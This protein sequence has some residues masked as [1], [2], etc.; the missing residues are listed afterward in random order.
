MKA[1]NRLAIALL[2][3]FTWQVAAAAAADSITLSAAAVKEAGIVIQSVAATRF[4]PKV[5]ARGSLLDPSPVLSL[6]SS[7]SAATAKLVAAR[8][9][10]R[11]SQQQEARAK[12]LFGNNQAISEQKFQQAEQAAA[13]AQA[14]FTEAQSSRTALINEA[15][16]DW[17]SALAA[18]L[19]EN[20]NPLL[21]QLSDGRAVLIGLSL[22]P[23]TALPSPAEHAMAQAAGKHF[24]ISLIG[25]VRRMVG[26]YP[27]E[28]FL[29][30]A[31]AQPGAPIGTAIVAK[32]PSGPQRNGVRV[33]AAAV[34]WRNGDPLVFRAL[35]KNAFEPVRIATG[36]QIDGDYFVT[37]GLALGEQVV[38]RGGGFLLGAGW[39]SH[40]PP[41][42]GD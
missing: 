42:G 15:T 8:A 27:G 11:F 2:G 34:V 23:A 3:V 36:A 6:Y 13:A 7:L 5:E 33:P 35:R 41:S 32:L 16:V 4:S 9:I 20:N 12:I 10:L 38:V 25:P 31:A 22:P 19:Q 29:Y 30:Q 40:G 39:R 26:F 14:A 28:S 37:S 1:F 18:S 24:P 17:G 21:L